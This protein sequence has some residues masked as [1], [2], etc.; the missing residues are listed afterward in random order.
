[1][2]SCFPNLLFPKSPCG[3]YA[4]VGASVVAMFLPLQPIAGAVLSY[5]FLGTSIRRGTLV[6][7]VGL[8]KSNPVDP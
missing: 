8:Y 3:R 5:T 1:V 2:I 7:G 4:A 6:G